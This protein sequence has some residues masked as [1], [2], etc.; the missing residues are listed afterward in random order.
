MLAGWKKGNQE[1]NPLEQASAPET[2]ANFQTMPSTMKRAIRLAVC[3][4]QI[5]ITFSVRWIES[6]SPA[7]R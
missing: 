7:N 1:L 5:F 4:V 2:A 3:F 6:F